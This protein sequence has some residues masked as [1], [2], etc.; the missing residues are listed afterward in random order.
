MVVLALSALADT[1]FVVFPL[2]SF[3]AAS[4]ADDTFR[5]V[6]WLPIRYFL[7]FAVYEIALCQ[8]ENITAWRKV[9]F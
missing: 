7:L 9:S 2:G 8:Y 5:I 1:T 4:F 3:C 6:T